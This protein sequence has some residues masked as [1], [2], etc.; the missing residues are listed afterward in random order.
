MNVSS[1]TA[2]SAAG[3]LIASLML[4]G[5][6]PDATPDET[7]GSQWTSAEHFPLA[8]RDAPILAWTGSEVLVAGGDTGS[9][10][11]P[12]ASC[13]HGDPAAD[14]AAF[15]PEAGTWRRIADAPVPIPYGAATFGA[16][17]LVVLLDAR[18]LLYSVA[19][20]TWSWEELPATLQRIAGLNLVA[21]GENILVIPSSDE[22]GDAPDALWHVPTDTWSE[23]PKDPIGPAFNRLL[24]PTP[25]GLILTAHEL[26]TNPGS[27][28]PSLTLV[29][30]L[31]RDTQSWTTLDPTEQIGGWQWFWTG[32]RLVSPELGQADGGHENN[33]GRSYP[34]GG[35][36]DPTN[37]TWQPLPTPP[38]ALTDAWLP[39]AQGGGRFST[40]SGFIYED[41]AETW[42]PLG[43][44][45][46]SAGNPWGAIWA[47]DRL[48]VVGETLADGTR[49]PDT[50]VYEPVQ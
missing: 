33:W 24:T 31:D 35:M 48:V 23:L 18:L 16:G 12:Y 43:R 34:V 10:C 42:T 26:V 39:S 9:P 3:V 15:D 14:G 36:I 5:C 1:R 29:A 17:H 30:R 21:D 46:D 11:P 25:A 2:L 13:A 44:P 4:A 28:N 37:G 27:E 20:D 40:S 47:G 32:K 49:Q 38:E 19:D 41:V 50:W 7:G 45:S 8:G 6:M 22:F